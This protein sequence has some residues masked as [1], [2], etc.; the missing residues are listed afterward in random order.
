[1]DI[2]LSALV[3]TLLITAILCGL[4]HSLKSDKKEWKP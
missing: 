4:G 1:M 3:L 2:F